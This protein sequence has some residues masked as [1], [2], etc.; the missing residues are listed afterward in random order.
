MRVVW[1][2][3]KD[4]SVLQNLGTAF[5]NDAAKPLKPKV[6]RCQGLALQ[7]FF[8]MEPFVRM[9]ERER[10]KGREKSLSAYVHLHVC[11]H[12]SKGVFQSLCAVLL[13]VLIA[14]CT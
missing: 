2:F 4:C 1:G 7:W 14:E 6:N 9:R 12:E 8:L 11:V 5:T 10:E 13:V 3:G